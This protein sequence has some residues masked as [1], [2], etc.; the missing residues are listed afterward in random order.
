[1]YTRR[2]RNPLTRAR[3]STWW[4]L[5]VCPTYSELTGVSRGVTV[6][7]VTSTGPCC[8]AGGLCLLQPARSA[9]AISQTDIERIRNVLEKPC[10]RAA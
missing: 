2:S 8:S 7:T 4:E 9:N 5:S 10:I 3:I 6:M 1:M